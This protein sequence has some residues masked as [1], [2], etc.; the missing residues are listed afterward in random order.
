MKSAIIYSSL[1][2]NTRQLAESIKN[3]LNDEAIYCGKPTDEALECDTLYVGF[4][5]QGFD[6][7]Q[8]IKDF[9]AKLSNKKI[10][11]FG[12]AGYNNTP[13]YFE[14][15]LA[16]VKKNIDSSNEI[17]GEFMCQGK[18]S[19]PKQ[20]AIKRMD[21]AKFESMRA[22]IEMGASHPDSNDINNLLKL[23]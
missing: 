11:L 18:V 22:N 12:T 21:A 10:F 20:E 23:L 17:I 15:I 14:P 5:T 9:L 19:A 2:K 8:D 1:T 4:W 7:P 6:A 13:E 3:H 16:T